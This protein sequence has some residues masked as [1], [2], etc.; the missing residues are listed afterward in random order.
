MCPYRDTSCA[1]DAAITGHL[2]GKYPLVIPLRARI[3]LRHQY[4]PDT[5]TT[6][7]L[8]LACEIV[9]DP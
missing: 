1:D 3:T 9:I 6:R 8:F 2:L 7:G 4:L 5:I